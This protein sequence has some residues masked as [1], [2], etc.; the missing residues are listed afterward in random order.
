MYDYTIIVWEVVDKVSGRGGQLW[1]GGRCSRKTGKVT[2]N[3]K[4]LPVDKLLITFQRSESTLT[5]G[6]TRLKTLTFK[7]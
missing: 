3:V 6:I 1:G 2:F 7:A 4:I 5:A